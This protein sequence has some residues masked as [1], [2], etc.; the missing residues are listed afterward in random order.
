MNK[1]VY[2]EQTLERGEVPFFKIGTF[3]GK[4]DAFISA[5][6]F[7]EYRNLYPYPKPG[8]L[9]LS[10]AG[11]IGR[12][13][14]YAGER[15]YFQDSNIVWLEHDERLLNSFLK[16]YY[17]N[18]TWSSLEGSTIKRLYNKDILDASICLPSTG[19]QRA[20]GT[21]FDRLD[22]LITLHQRK[23]AQNHAR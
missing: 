20:I 14:E 5:E 12:I 6:L 11:S 18:Q 22:S 19:E 10:A 9:L 17:N 13:V 8:T 16:V 7:E 2:K 3:G 23:G 1:R 21:L 4:P 15:A